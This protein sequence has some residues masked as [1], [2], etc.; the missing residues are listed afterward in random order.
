MKKMS[1]GTA[2]VYVV[3]AGL[4]EIGFAVTLKSAASGRS[5]LSL[6]ASVSFLASSLTLLSLAARQ[7]PI[8]SA[9][10][11][12]TGIGAGGSA[13]VG[14]IAFGESA[15]PSR[16]VCLALIVLGAVGLRAVD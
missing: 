4:L 5:V 3:L 6:L 10:A 16:L 1:A 15:S 9:Y 11:V 2:W 7:L 12:W 8:G 13:V 14:M